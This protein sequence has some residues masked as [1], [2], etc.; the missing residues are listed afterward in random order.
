MTVQVNDI[1]KLIIQALPDAK[2]DVHCYSGDD[3]FEAVV[4]SSAFAGKNRV[5]QHKMVYAAL[6]DHM[7]AAIHALALTTSAPKE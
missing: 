5:S 7:R 6:G 2:V 4:V 1:K 3:H